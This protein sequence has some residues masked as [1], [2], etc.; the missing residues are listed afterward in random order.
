[1]PDLGPKIALPFSEPGVWTGLIWRGTPRTSHGEPGISPRLRSH[2]APPEGP[3][4]GD[5]CDAIVPAGRGCFVA[6]GTE[7]AAHASTARVFAWTA[8]VIVINEQ[9]I[10]VFRGPRPGRQ[11][12][13]IGVRWV[14][15]AGER[16]RIGTGVRASR[17]VVRTNR[18]SAPHDWNAVSGSAVDRTPACGTPAAIPGRALRPGPGAGLAVGGRG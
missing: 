12:T 5:P 1:M 13:Y 6:V 10:C 3:A 18:R 14:N 4:G 2:P 16:N 7:Q 17:R 15:Q 11:F 9:G 8:R